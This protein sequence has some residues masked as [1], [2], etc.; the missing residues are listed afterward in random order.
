MPRVL[1]YTAIP[2]LSIQAN[3]SVAMRSIVCLTR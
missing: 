1:P 3:T 2:F